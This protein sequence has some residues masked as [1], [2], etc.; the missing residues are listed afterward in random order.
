MLLDEKETSGSG[1]FQVNMTPL[2]DVSLVLVVTLLLMTPLALEA[3]IGVR[4]ETARHEPTEPPLATERVPVHVV[5]ESLVQVGDRML[6]RDHM[7]PVL[8]AMLR[9]PEYAGV[10]LGCNGDVS[11]AAFVDVLDKARLSGADDIAIS[12]EGTGS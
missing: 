9:Q 8:G 12:D 6:K 5:S 2:I 1:L 10:A 7:M 3:R 4:D 11:H